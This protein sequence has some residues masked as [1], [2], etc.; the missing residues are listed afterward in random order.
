M[1]K[2]IKINGVDT[3]IHCYPYTPN[4]SYTEEEFKEGLR[5]RLINT[6]ESSWIITSLLTDV[7]RDKGLESS[8]NESKAIEVIH[9]AKKIAIIKYIGTVD[10]EWIKDLMDIE[11]N[12]DNGL[13]FV[14]K[15][16]EDGSYI[17]KE[18]YQIKID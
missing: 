5:K 6:I 12:S 2:L 17:N 3:T 14:W 18:P 13:L 9:Y 7:I 15:L 11:T 8:F 4:N 16:K 10:P 1:D